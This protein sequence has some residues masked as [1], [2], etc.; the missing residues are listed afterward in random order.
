[1]KSVTKQLLDFVIGLNYVDLTREVIDESKRMIF[2]CIGVAIAGLKTDKGRFGLAMAN[3]LGGAPE[4][5]IWG[6]NARASCGAAAFANGELINALD[7]DSLLFPTHAPPAIIPASLVL[8]ECAGGTGKDLILSTAIGCELSI[9]L[10]KAIRGEKR[11]F[12]TEEGSEIGKIVGTKHS[13]SVV[14]V[15]VIAG[16]AGAGKVIKLNEPKMANAIGLAAHFT[17]IPQARWKSET[18]MPMTKYISAGWAS[19]GEVFALQ[20]ADM[21]YIADTMALDGEVGLWRFF[22]GDRWNPSI[23]LENLG[24]EWKMLKAVEYKPYP[25]CRHLH[26]ALDCFYKIIEENQVSSEDIKSVRVQTQSSIAGGLYMNKQI[27][28]HVSAQFSLPYVIAAAANGISLAEWQN[29]DKIGDPRILRF[30]DKVYIQPHPDFSKVQIQEPGSNMTVVEVVTESKAFK[31][32]GKYPRGLPSPEFLR[33]TD[34]D[35]IKKFRDNISKVLPRE[36]VD[37][38]IALMSELEDEKKIS[39]IVE[40]VTL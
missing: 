16:A 29:P 1:M 40:Q 12:E 6:T 9:R 28:D 36:K 19:L 5:A 20:L 34:A 21:G 25:C 11:L 8:A 13:V 31:E 38:A 22:G 32:E 3:R 35:I 23:L 30:M 14:G 2:D 39:E 27:R 10:A 37:R 4:A 7:Y 17:P 33:M 26:I 18:P 24:R 15:A